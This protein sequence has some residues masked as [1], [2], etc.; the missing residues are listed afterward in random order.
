[1]VGYGIYAVLWIGSCIGRKQSPP[2]DRKW[3][4]E[5]ISFK[6]SNAPLKPGQYFARCI[7]WVIGVRS[8]GTL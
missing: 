3:Q 5:N 6:D 4:L 7:G 1:M 8:A 2:A